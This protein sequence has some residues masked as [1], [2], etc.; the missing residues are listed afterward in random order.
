MYSI[1]SKEKKLI[2]DIFNKL[3]EQE[4]MHWTKKSIAHEASVFVVW[5]QMSNDEKKNR[6]VIDIRDLNKIVK[7]DFYSM[8]LQIDII[9]VVTKS[10]FISIIDAAVFFYQFWVRSENR[11]KL[12][13]M[14][15]RKQK[16]FFVAFM[17]F[18][19]SFIYAQRWINIILR[20]LKYCCKA[21]INDI[22]IFSLTLEKHLRHLSV[23]FQRLLDYDIKLN[24]CKTFLSFSSIALFEQLVDELDLHAVKD[25]ITVI[26][27]W[28]FST[29]L[30]VLKI[31]L[32]FIEWL[33]NYMT[34][35]AQKAESLQQRK[36]MLLKKSSQKESTRKTFFCKILFQFIDR[37]LKSFELVQFVFKNSQFLTHFNLIR[38]FLI[39]VDV[40]KKDFETF[41]YHI[42]KKRDDMT[43]SIAIKS[44]V[45]LN[46]ILTSVE[47]R[48]W[49]T[50]LKIIA[51]IW[52]VKK[53][54]HMIKA[55]KQSIIIWT[56][57]S[58]TTIII[59]Q[60]K[61][62]IINIDKLNLRLII[63][64][65]YLSQF[66]L[67]IKHKSERDH[68]ILNVLSRLSSFEND[69]FTK[70]RDFTKNHD[71]L[72]DIDAYAEILVKM[73][74]VFKKRL[75]QNYKTNNE[76]TSLYEMLTE[77][78][79]IQATRQEIV[80]VTRKSSQKVT[81][82][83]LKFERRNNLIYH[84]NRFTSKVRLCIFKSLIKDIF[85]MTHDDFMHVDF[86]RVFATIFETIY[87]RRLAHRL[88]QYIVYYSKCLLN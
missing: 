3:H 78:S 76:W 60:I 73:F 42:K 12:I 68:I 62:S 25:K 8:F 10:R 81:H 41:V 38:Q 33:R 17:N 69:D 43:K 39:N 66:N 2:N 88:K 55:F 16:Y 27:N 29:N 32:E 13:V 9:F 20:N 4:K 80:D 49:L 5:R 54:H 59:K 21:F 23:I 35:Y 65:M 86:H 18:K 1:R 48:Y 26:L 40:F 47:K 34:W 71:I 67:N 28:K 36:I 61:L 87:I 83:E 52:I 45:F 75:I 30:K 79:S 57:H 56:N 53:L 24:S 7:F 74:S 44:I 84:L 11:H 85:R 70:N 82:E 19:N 15:H 6:V 63:I 58:V 22:T 37:E 64:V 31:Y 14:S 50:K 77:I 46:K 72:N 51:I